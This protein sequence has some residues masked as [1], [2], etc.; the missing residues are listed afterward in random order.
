MLVWIYFD[1]GTISIV[2]LVIF[3]VIVDRQQFLRVKEERIRKALL[4]FTFLV[5]FSFTKRNTTRSS[6]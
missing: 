3:L 4:R 2:L 5:S 6:P 1:L